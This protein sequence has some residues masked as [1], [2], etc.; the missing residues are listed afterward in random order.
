MDQMKCELYHTVDAQQAIRKEVNGEEQELYVCSSCAALESRP[1]QKQPTLTIEGALPPPQ[2]LQAI[3]ETLPELMNLLM[4]ASLEILGHNR[5]ASSELKCPQCGITR[6]EYRKASRLGCAICYET[7]IKD[8]DGVIQ[9]MNRI[10]RHV[11]KSPRIPQPSAQ[12]QKLMRQLKVAASTLNP[13]ETEALK[14]H[15]RELGWFPERDDGGA[16]P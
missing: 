4:D 8:L 7:F 13:A 6:A 1:K 10:P 9:E 5:Q 3:Q 2:V 12:T 14:N 16:T 11:G 15:I